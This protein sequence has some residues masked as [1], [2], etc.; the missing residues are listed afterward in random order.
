M[1]II[2]YA[3]L[4][5]SEIKRY[6][7]TIH[8]ETDKLVTLKLTDRMDIRKGKPIVAFRSFIKDFIVSVK[9]K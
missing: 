3:K 2:E 9:L 5:S 4:G 1:L 8:S 6:R 7:G